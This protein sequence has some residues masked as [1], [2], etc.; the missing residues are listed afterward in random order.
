MSKHKTITLLLVLYA[1]ET[2]SLTQREEYIL[3]AFGK[4]LKKIHVSKKED[5]VSEQL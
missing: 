2:W 1:C 4:V 5:E 3:Q